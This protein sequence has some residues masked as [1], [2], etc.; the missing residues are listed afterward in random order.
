M[1]DI[2]EDEI[3]KIAEKGLTA[4]NIETAYKLVDMYKDLKQAESCDGGYS[5]DYDRDNSYGRHY[6][7]GHYSRDYDDGMSHKVRDLDEYLDEYIGNLEK[8]Y[9]GATQ[10]E[11]DTIRRY[12]AKI[13]NM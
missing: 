1:C 5:N 2:I 10:D 9:N 13:R 11:K 4:S 6:V 8:M 12:I 7:R 3:S